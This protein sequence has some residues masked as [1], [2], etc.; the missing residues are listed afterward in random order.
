MEN[1]DPK[2]MENNDPKKMENNDND[3]RQIEWQVSFF[4]FTA[5]TMMT[6][7]V[8]NYTDFSNP[9]ASDLINLDTRAVASC[10]S[11]NTFCPRLYRL[12][13][14]SPA[15]FLSNSFTQM[16]VENATT[17]PCQHYASQFA[18]L[19]QEKLDYEYCQYREWG[20]Q[21]NV[22]LIIVLGGL[23]MAV[24]LPLLFILQK[25]VSFSGLSERFFLIGAKV[26]FVICSVLLCGLAAAYIVYF[27]KYSFCFNT[28]R[29]FLGFFCGFLAAMAAN[30]FSMTRNI[31]RKWSPDPNPNPNPTE[32]EKKPEG[33]TEDMYHEFLDKQ[34]DA[35][36]WIATTVAVVLVLNNSDISQPFQDES[37]LLVSHT[38]A[39]C[40][41]WNTQC[42]GTK[43]T[44]IGMLLYCHRPEEILKYEQLPANLMQKVRD[45]TPLISNYP[46]TYCDNL[47]GHLTQ[48]TSLYNVY[49]NVNFDERM[50][51]FTAAM[52]C[53]FVAAGLF[54]YIPWGNFVCQKDQQQ[55][56]KHLLSA[57]V[58][59]APMCILS[60]FCAVYM[61]KSGDPAGVYEA[62]FWVQ[63]SACVL[64]ICV[65]SVWMLFGGSNKK[66]TP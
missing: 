12:Y 52:A 3:R 26:V 23:S 34:R 39:F 43:D 55:T 41:D 38:M 59:I 57:P 28:K 50:I 46:T 32:C 44:G 7:L 51:N 18:Q 61:L 49:D 58:I 36:C 53:I 14:D 20:K 22:C 35:V 65:I 60:V 27:S 8:T 6:M 15:D 42:S 9:R 62:F 1:N 17:W 45:L 11:W 19:G 48:L 64:N 4:K 33:A 40:S 5:V 21:N 66:I 37:Q 24:N 2:K 31:I 29:E 56:K 63:F 25:A 10:A 30:A 16:L 47:V 13:C 54:P